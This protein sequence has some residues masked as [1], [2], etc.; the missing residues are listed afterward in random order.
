MI[1]EQV[2]PYVGNVLAAILDINGIV[3]E[4][5]FCA[6]TL[7]VQGGIC[8]VVHDDLEHVIY[9]RTRTIKLGEIIPKQVETKFKGE[10]GVGTLAKR[11]QLNSS[12]FAPIS[13]YFQA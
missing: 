7:N 6:R 13:L 12:F 8:T 9:D 10:K 2:Q 11:M 3:V 5:L 4:Q 1:A